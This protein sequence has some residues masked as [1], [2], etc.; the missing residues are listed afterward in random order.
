[1]KPAKSH[2]NSFVSFH[3]VRTKKRSWIENSFHILS[4]GEH[5]HIFVRMRGPAKNLMRGPPQYICNVNATYRYD[6]H[7][8]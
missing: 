2:Y 7:R 3:E 8:L 4:H 1:M 5:G 6:A